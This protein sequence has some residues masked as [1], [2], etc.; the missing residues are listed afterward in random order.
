MPAPCPEP[1]PHPKDISNVVFYLTNC[2]SLVGVKLNYGVD[3]NDYLQPATL[4][5]QVARIV[6]DSP[7]LSGFEVVGYTVKAGRDE[8]DFGTVFDQFGNTGGHPA[9]AEGRYNGNIRLPASE[10]DSL[11]PIDLG[12]GIAATSAALAEVSTLAE[13]AQTD[14][15]GIDE[16]SAWDDPATDSPNGVVDAPGDSLLIGTLGADV[17]KWTL[18]EPGAVDTISDFSMAP[19][20][21]GGDVLDLRDL[22][23]TERQESLHSYLHFEASEDGGTLLK[24][25]SSGAFT[26]DPAHD[27]AVVHQTIELANVNLLDLGSDQQIIE[28]LIS[29]NKL[30]VD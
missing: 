15:S 11:E 19:P 29:Q 14:E 21:E 20:S 22:L 25:S 1:T 9:L 3:I 6:N 8:F 26:G 7:Y 4:A 12:D 23:P 27:A 13:S 28:S 30:I 10:V 16:S 24:V 17:F 18:A 2:D 5:K